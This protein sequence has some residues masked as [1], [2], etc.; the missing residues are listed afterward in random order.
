MATYIVKENQLLNDI[1]VEHYGDHDRGMVDLI[2]RNPQLRGYTDNV[3][4]RQEL[5]VGEPF[6]TQV[7]ASLN[8]ARVCSRKA[9]NIYR[10]I[11]YDLVSNCAIL[12]V[13]LGGEERICPYN[14]IRVG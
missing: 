11:G 10:G 14:A 8:G 12:D 2:N 5:N 6:N 9:A 13:D 1:A 4:V 7:V 3:L